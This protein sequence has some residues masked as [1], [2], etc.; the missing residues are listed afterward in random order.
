M[1]KSF[2][3]TEDDIFYLSRVIFCP[4]RLN[5]LSRATDLTDL[6]M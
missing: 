4:R 5:Y 2:I 3:V 6:S 1:A